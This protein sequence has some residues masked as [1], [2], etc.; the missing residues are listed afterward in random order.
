MSLQDLQRPTLHFSGCL[1]HGLEEQY[2]VSPSD[3]KKDP[4]T[5]CEVM[6]HALERICRHC[7]DRQC[8]FPQNL[9]IQA[10]NCVREM[11]NQYVLKF[12]IA[13]LLLCDHIVSMTWN[14]LRVGHTHEDIGCQAM[15]ALP[16]LIFDMVRCR[17]LFLCHA[18]LFLHVARPTIRGDCVSVGKGTAPTNTPALC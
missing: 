7:D 14:F 5:E 10:D 2:H 16:L 4:N 8:E 18:A 17:P 6:C 1:I 11:K 9:F 13:L 15:F 3:L 12:G